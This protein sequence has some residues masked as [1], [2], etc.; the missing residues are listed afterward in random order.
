ML[1]KRSC[2]QI[3]CVA[4]STFLFAGAMQ[5]PAFGALTT[6]ATYNTPNPATPA[7][8]FTDN[9]SGSYSITASGADLW[10]TADNG[11]WLYDPATTTAGDFT[12]IVRSTSFNTAA[13]LSP[14]AG[15]W[16]RTGVM[17]RANRDV[18]EN[19]GAGNGIVDANAANTATIRKSGLTNGASGQFAIL[20]QGRRYHGGATDRLY[21]EA[22]GSGGLAANQGN[23]AWLALHRMGNFFYS[24]YAPDVGNAPGAWSAPQMREVS[25]DLAG[26]LFVGL[27]HQ[28][29]LV[30]ARQSGQFRLFLGWRRGSHVQFAGHAANARAVHLRPTAE[31]QVEPHGARRVRVFELR[32]RGGSAQ[33][34]TFNGLPGHLATPRDINENRDLQG[35]ISASRLRS[36][37]LSQNT[38]VG[39]GDGAVEGEWR[40]T[41][42]G[43]DHVW[44]GLGPDRTPPGSGVAGAFERFNR[45][46]NVP[47]QLINDEPNNSGNGTI[48]EDAAEII[49]AGQQTIGASTTG[50]CA[51]PAVCPAVVYE[52]MGR[53]NDL[54]PNVNT[55]SRFQIVE[56]ETQL[57]ARPEIPA[58][59][60]QNG[61]FSVHMVYGHRGDIQH[62]RAVEA[63]AYST[64]IGSHHHSYQPTVN[65]KD[66]GSG[67]GLMAGG[68]AF[69]G[70]NPANADENDFV[71][72]ARGVVNIPE[73]GDLYVRLPRRRRL[74]I[75]NPGPHVHDGH[76][77][78]GRRRR[79][80]SQPRRK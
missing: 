30:A 37:G 1:R 45:P 14:L 44:Q 73:D 6:L 60:I 51:A 71:L 80:R 76:Q 28:A 16:G 18:A 20:Q 62:V 63:L 56:Y 15:E 19:A 38:W 12:A 67:D 59:P 77:P 11:S 21:G 68:R 17:A 75:A 57:D 3:L 48:G 46:P 8:S 52:S 40:L 5:S 4:L 65:F 27:A 53:W 79:Y 47:Q 54:P 24:Q 10:G 33:T 7:P 13:P 25:P 39:V 78:A 43:N 70:S 55:S 61:N 35:L 34:K 23:M 50:V 69:P 31:R 26:P 9:G 64:G 22:I 32:Q 41:D 49:R 72:F 66:E 29:A 74:A 2:G 58:L 36:E 42:A